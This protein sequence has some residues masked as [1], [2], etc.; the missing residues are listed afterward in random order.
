MIAVFVLRMQLLAGTVTDRGYWKLAE[1]NGAASVAVSVP[2]VFVAPL[3]VSV[4]VIVLFTVDV[5]V[6]NAKFAGPLADPVGVCA[7]SLSH[8]AVAV[9]VPLAPL[10]N[11]HEYGT[12]I[13]PDAG[14]ETALPSGPGQTSEPIASVTSPVTASKSFGLRTVIVPETAH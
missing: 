5:G 1:A 9:F 8:V 2:S 14:T 3:N 10:D 11:E 7:A 4:T 6:L 12:L 13:E